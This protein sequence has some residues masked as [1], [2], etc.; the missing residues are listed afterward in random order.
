MGISVTAAHTIF[1]V[2]LL[3][4]GSALSAAVLRSH[5]QVV[6]ARRSDAALRDDIAHTD[7]T[8]TDERWAPPSDTISFDLLNDGSVVLDVRELDFVVD[9][10][11]STDKVE[12]GWT[13]G[14]A[15]SNW[16]TPGST[17]EISLAPFPGG[18][19]EDVVVAAENGVTAV[20]RR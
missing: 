9:G 3:V 5:T 2:A 12:S 19:P 13:I 10:V 4:G 1:I 20:W 11:W 14:G 7:M 6:E 8:F 15:S 17:L 16:W 18:E